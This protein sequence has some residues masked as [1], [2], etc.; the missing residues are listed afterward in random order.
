MVQDIAPTFWGDLE[1][2][3]Y[4]GKY[5][6]HRKKVQAKAAG[7]LEDVE[8]LKSI[9]FNLWQFQNLEGQSIAYD[10]PVEILPVS[11]SS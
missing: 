4:N 6:E 5:D 9:S 1:I 11:G 8:E 2:S 3:E 10:D 7:K